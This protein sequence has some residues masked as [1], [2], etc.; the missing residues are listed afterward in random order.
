MHPTNLVGALSKRDMQYFSIFWTLWKS[1]G[2]TGHALMSL[3]P[4][5]GVSISLTAQLTHTTKKDLLKHK[6]TIV[7]YDILCAHILKYMNFYF[8]HNFVMNP[9]WVTEVWPWKYGPIYY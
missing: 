7:W 2:E 4:Q 3:Q 5:E 8:V 9:K 1:H 6:K